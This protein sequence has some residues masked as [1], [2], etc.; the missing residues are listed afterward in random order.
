[1]NLPVSLA[2]LCAAIVSTCK[3]DSAGFIALPLRPS[4]E[5]TL[6]KRD[7]LETPLIDVRIA[8]VADIAIGIPPQPMALA[9]DTGSSPIW[10]NPVCTFARNQGLCETFPRYSS[11]LSDTPPER[12]PEIDGYQDYYSGSWALLEGYEDIFWWGEN[13]GVLQPFGVAE[14]SDGSSMGFIGLGPDLRTGFD[15]NVSQYSVLNTLVSEGVINSRVFSLG[16]EQPPVLFS[17]NPGTVLENRTID[18]QR[19]WQSDFSYL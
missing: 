16:L 7:T 5:K 6:V 8:Y 1:M 14:D 13:A 12:V 15:G 18:Q 11:N 10:V 9:I 4:G 17:D 3:G 19:Y 2:V